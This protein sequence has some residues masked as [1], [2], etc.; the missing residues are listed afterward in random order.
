MCKRIR[1][2]EENGY[3]KRECGLYEKG[4]KLYKEAEVIR[5][6]FIKYKLAVSL[7][8]ASKKRICDKLMFLKEQ[9]KDFINE[10]LIA[11]KEQN[12]DIF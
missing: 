9:E 7:N 10:L 4:E 8:E 1:F 3:I 6:L 5:N 11:M 12:E 2:L